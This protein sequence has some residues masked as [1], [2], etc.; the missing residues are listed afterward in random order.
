MTPVLLLGVFNLQVWQSRSFTSYRGWKRLLYL[1]FFFFFPSSGNTSA[2]IQWLE[3]VWKQ[4]GLQFS[5]LTSGAVHLA[6]EL[7]FNTG[8]NHIA[9]DSLERLSVLS[10]GSLPGAPR[11]CLSASTRHVTLLKRLLQY[12]EAAMCHT[13]ARFY[14]N[15]QQQLPS[16]TVPF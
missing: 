1:L 8:R 9:S 6:V 3:S 15:T 10:T 7:C 13:D 16:V 2:P 4:K 11:S 5:V 14:L 12:L